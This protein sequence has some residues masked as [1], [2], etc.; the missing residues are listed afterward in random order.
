M[1]QKVPG[2]EL[3]YLLRLSYSAERAAAFAY[4]GHAGSVKDPEEKRELKKIEAEEWGHREDLGKIL[5][6]FKIKPSWFLEKKYYSIGKG[7]SLSCY[8]TGW[9]LPM[10]FAG[11][12]ESGNVNEY[13]RLYRLMEAEEGS[14][15]F[16]PCIQKMAKV[17]K[18]HELYF[19]NRVQSHWML[20]Y[21]Q[22]IFRWGPE[23]SLNS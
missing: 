1:T 22:W 18:E 12:L 11:R 3:K 8:L 16:L 17:E 9:F 13:S 19:A 23:K 2:K 20:P 7:V 14:D 6:H 21:F 5:A 15:V 4:Q 10:Y